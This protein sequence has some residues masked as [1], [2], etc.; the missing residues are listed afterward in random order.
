[1]RWSPAGQRAPDE[2]LEPIELKELACEAARAAGAKKAE[3]VLVLDLRGLSPIAD[4]FV[5]ASATNR[6]QLRAIAEATQEEMR[7]RGLALHHAEGVDHTG[8][9]LLDYGD[10][11]IHL[12]LPDV[13]SFYGLERLW[14][15]AKEIDYHDTMG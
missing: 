5:I 13:R 9:V 15:D 1:M 3:H 4:Y 6:V 12:F 7:R 11:V 8:W 10:L 14:G 2:T